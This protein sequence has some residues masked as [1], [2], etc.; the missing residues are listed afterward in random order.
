[1]LKLNGIKCIILDTVETC[2][3]PL[4]H[5]LALPNYNPLAQ[6]ASH[7]HTDSLP[8]YPPPPNPSPLQ[9]PTHHHPNLVLTPPFPAVACCAY[10]PAGWL[11]L[12]GHWNEWLGIAGI[13]QNLCKT[14][15]VPVWAQQNKVGHP[16]YLTSTWSRFL[17]C[18]YVSLHNINRLQQILF[19]FFKQAF[20]PNQYS[21]IIVCV[22]VCVHAC[23]HV[24]MCAASFLL[25]F[26][27]F[28]PALSLNQAYCFAR[29]LC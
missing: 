6:Q 26:S 22:C 18:S 14:T 19:L 23:M 11:C 24:W 15:D 25:L 5:V 16:A 17:H 27:S 20:H 13:V 2:I 29:I 21:S 3:A 12:N 9:T 8:F 1:M 28:F 4:T 7:S 10:L